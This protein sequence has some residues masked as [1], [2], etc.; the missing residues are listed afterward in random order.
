VAVD[1]QCY[2][3]MPDVTPRPLSGWPG[4][5]RGSAY[6]AVLVVIALLAALVSGVVVARRPLPQVD[7]T[8]RIEGLT[9]KVEVLRDDHGIPQ[10]YA[11][12]ADDLFR[13]QGFVQAQ[14]RFFEMDFRRHVTAGRMSEMLGEDTVEADMY[15]RTMGWRRVATSEYD[16]LAPDTKAYLQAYSDGVNAYLKGR[17][18]TELSV[19]YTVLGLTGLDYEPEPWTPIDSLAWLK[20]MA[21]DLAG[22]MDEEV[23]RTR[24]SLDRTPG[25]VDELYPRYPYDRNATIVGGS[26]ESSP[27]TDARPAP[28]PAAQRALDAVQRGVDAIPDLMGHG[29]GIGSNSW[30]VSG[31]HTASGKPLLANDPHLDVSIPGIWYQMG[32]HCTT[33]NEDCPFDV[34]GFTFSGMPGVVIG[35]NRDIAWGMTNLDPDVSDLFLEKVTGKTYLYGGKQV[36]L[37]ERDEVIRVA[38]RSSKLITVRS[39]GHGPLLSDVSAELS[40]VG[41]NAEVGAGA[42]VRD[43]GYAVALSWT[44][45]TPRPTADAIFMLDAARDWTDFRAAASRFAVPSQNLVYADTDGNI[46]YQAPGAI[47][48]RKGGRTGDYPA[49]GWLPGDDWSGRYVPFDQLPRVLNPP[50]GF[51]V[52]AN[53]AATGPDYPWYLGGA[54]DQGYRSQRIRRLLTQ[55]FGDGSRVDVEDMT[56]LQLDSRNPMAPELVPYLMRQLLTSEYYA[57]GQRLLLDWDFTQPA[58]SAAAA[59]FNVVWSNV[60]ELTFRDQLPESLW[61]DGGQR[62]MAVVSNLLRQPHSQWWDDTKTEGV[63]EDRDTILTQAMLDARDELTRKVA[64]SPKHWQWGRLHQLELK[65]QSLGRTG[66]GAV[67]ALL[68]RGPFEVGG[69][70]AVVDSTN[71]DVAKGY[72]VTSASSMR[73]VVDLDD[74]ERSRWVNLTGASGHVGSGHYRDQTPLWVKGDTLAWASGRDAVRTAAQ[75]RL[76]LEP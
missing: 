48:I 24:L 6:A 13:A 12:N 59:Y 46:G 36:P 76:V 75:H 49:E 14:D 2:G 15:I 19:E 56:R 20:A 65:N 73:M 1:C 68:N 40:S 51:I 57:D 39:T 54:P 33:V 62:W 66:I 29:D 10:V 31:D 32:L 71:W 43:N 35:H 44:A 60:L 47:P 22:N 42:P 45:L 5:A 21:W 58:D 7:G 16:L 26:D 41:A 72:D 8:L 50:E 23:D 74:L 55:Q 67:R 30:V 18:P 53:Q 27:G 9:S 64:L 34:S 61:P 52:A 70:G 37:T 11:E 4:W 63:V 17:S 25:Q 28:G 3:T 69:G 38:G